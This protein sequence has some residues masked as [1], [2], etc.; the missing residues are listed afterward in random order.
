M[1]IILFT[2]SFVIAI[3]VNAQTKTTHTYAVKGA[4]T[5][6]LDVYT[7]VNIKTNDSLPVLLWMHGGGF[8]GGARDNSA[9]QKLGEYAAQHGYIGVSISYRLTRK[10]KKTGFGC[11]CPR[12]EKVKTFKYAVEDYM[13]AALYIVIHKKGLQIAANKIIAGGSS[14]G[15]EGVLNAVFMREHFINNLDNYKSVKFAGVFSLAGAM[16][17]ANYIT[18][19][20]ALPIVLFHGTDDNLVPFGTAP[21]HYCNKDE[22]GYMVLDGAATIVEKLKELDKSYYFYSVKGGKHEMSG[23]PFYDL[24]HVFEFFDQSILNDKIVQTKKIIK[25]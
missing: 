22:P 6:K 13:D 7:P 19:D 9:E 16:V 14:A 24:D 15:A 2:L 1:K 23:V 25:K 20:N 21:H 10:G 5:L 11:N 3:A 12:E 17:N 4:D 18:K 8:A